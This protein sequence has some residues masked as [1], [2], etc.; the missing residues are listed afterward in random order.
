LNLLH[1]LVFFSI[2]T[3]LIAGALNRA[4]TRE[5]KTPQIVEEFPCVDPAGKP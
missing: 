5:R 1:T 2:K 3:I 4:K